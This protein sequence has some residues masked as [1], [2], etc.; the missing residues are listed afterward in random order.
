MMVN[1]EASPAAGSLRYI[2]YD[3]DAHLELTMFNGVNKLSTVEPVGTGAMRFTWHA[4][5]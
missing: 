3:A 5:Y 4:Y 1:A 2:N